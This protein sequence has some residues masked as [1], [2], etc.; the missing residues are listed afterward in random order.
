ME[1]PISN[2][3]V[4]LDNLRFSE[5]LIQTTN[6]AGQYVFEDLIVGE[7]YFVTVRSKS[8]VF[9]EPSKLITLNKSLSD[10]NFIDLPDLYGPYL[11][12]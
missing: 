1:R 6:K 2:V 7:T 10:L 12:R 3:Q 5:P 4:V 8:D 11:N 9:T